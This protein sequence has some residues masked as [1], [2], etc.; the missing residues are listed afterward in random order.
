MANTIKTKKPSRKSSQSSVITSSQRILKVNASLKVENIQLRTNVRTLQ[1][2][3]S[4]IKKTLSQQS[5]KEIIRADEEKY[6][7]I[8]HSSMDIIFM[9]D[10]AGK[11]L[12]VNDSMGNKLGYTTEELIGKSFAIFVPQM[13]KAKYRLELKNIYLRKEVKH[14][15]TKIYRKD[16]TLVDVEINGKLIKHNRANVGLGTIRDITERKKSEQKIVEVQTM[17]HRIINLLPVRVFWKDKNLK[18]LGCNEIFAKDAGKKHPNELLGKDDTTLVWKEQATL[19]QNDDTVIIN[20]GKPK[21]HFEEPQTTSNGKKVWLSTSKVPLT[22][23]EG[24]IIGVLGA[25]E[26]IT[27]RKRAEL[28]L[29]DSESKYHELY[30]LIRLMSDTMPDL[31]WAKDLDNKYIF[32]NKAMCDK[33][34]GAVDTSEP[35]G[36]TDLFFALRERQAHPEDPQWHTFGELCRDS[37]EVVVKEMKEMQ[38]D[39]YGNVKGKFLFLDVHKAPLFNDE[40]KLIGVVGS[41]RDIT[42]RK[43]IETELKKSQDRLKMFFNQSLD[44]FYFSM[45]DEPKAWNEN[46]NKEEILDYVFSH[47][48]MTEINDAMLKQYG[49]TREYFLHKSL[50]SFFRHDEEQGRLLRRKLFDDGHLHVE[51]N[52][53]KVDGTP[54]WIEGDYVCL[55]DD[56]H[57]ILGTFGIQRDITER[58]RIEEAQKLS[59]KRLNNVL[60]NSPDTIYTIDL[61]TGKANLLN[62]NDFYGYTKQELESSKS[63]LHTIFPDDCNIVFENWEKMR[64]GK[65]IEPIEYRIVKKDGEIVWI[66]QRITV[67]SRNADNTPNQLLVT[68]SDITVRKRTEETLRTS[69]EHQRFILQS[70][71]VAIYSS[72]MDPN[73]DTNWISGDVKRVTG[74]EVEEYLSEPDFW[75]KRIHPDDAESIFEMYKTLSFNDEIILEYR[76]KCKDGAYHWF[77]DRTILKEKENQKEYLGIIT[78]VTERKKSENLI[79][80]SEISYRGLFN[81]VSDAIY[82]LNEKGQFIDVNPGALK[83]YGYQYE[84]LVG[85]TPEFVS[86]PG[87]NDMAMVVEALKKAMEGEPQQ[88][89]FWGLR[90]NGEI[91]LKDVRLNKGTYFGDDVIIALAQDISE[92]KKS[93]KKI[94]ENEERYRIIVDNLHQAYFEADGRAIFTYFN[95]ELCIISGFNDHELI[96]TSSLRLV[97]KEHR[98]RVTESYFRW[99]K[100]KCTKSSIEFLTQKKN[101]EKI[102]VEQTTHFEFDENG[103][104]IKGANII[105]DIHERKMAEEALITEKNLLMTLVNTIPDRVYVKDKESRFLL[106]NTAHLHALGAQ[107]QSEAL[108]KTDHDFRKQEFADQYLSDDRSVIQTDTPINNKEELTI[109]PSGELGT[110][111]VNKV[112]LHN[113]KG[114]VIGLVGVSRDISERKRLEEGIQQSEIFFRSV[115]EHSSSGMRLTDENGI[116]I[117]VNKSFCNM[118]GKTEK[119]LVGSS[120]SVIYMPEAHTHIVQKHMERFSTRSVPISTEQELLLWNGK[121]VWFKVL[122]SFIEFGSTKSLLLGIFSDITEQ[123]KSEQIIQDLQRRESIGILAGGIAHDFNNLLASMMGNL[124]L[125][126]TRMVSDHPAIKNLDRTMVAVERAATLTK[127]MLAYSGKGRFQSIAIDL[128][129]VVKEHIELFEAS[130][131]KNVSIVTHL[132][133]NPVFIKGDPGQIEQ[134]IMNLIINGGEAIGEKNG[135]VDISVFTIYLTDEE[136]EPFGKYNNKEMISGEYALFQVVDNGIGIR[137]ETIAKIFDPF[138]TTK[139]VGRGL[140]LSAVLGI[141]RG[142]G[143]GIRVSSKENVGTTFQVIIPLLKADIE[144]YKI[145]H[146]DYDERSLSPTVLVIDDEQYIIDMTNDI[147]ESKKYHHYS[148]VDP[149]KGIS[150]FKDYWQSIDLVILDYAMPKMNGKEVLIELLKINPAIKVIMSSGYSEEELIHLMG[151]IKPSAFIQKPHRPEKLLSLITTVLNQS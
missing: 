21:L 33:L 10:K 8:A 83:M 124:S 126:K 84:E 4:K 28:A 114:D 99:K 61:A 42:E 44:G 41:G 71:P 140:G 106:N 133:P 11:I 53:L 50:N 105:K 18:Y 93:E 144:E 127:Q 139:F 60:E 137:E 143:G 66:G 130:L 27:E 134:I 92:R 15:E 128:V 68:L 1:Q 40:G 76:W 117:T 75:R 146:S 100:E 80:E 39:E 89:E 90:K 51:T 151:D 35:V 26:D 129:K 122:N 72:P 19:Y 55:Y 32:A 108:G 91:F 147:F 2:E 22:D 67:M 74:F 47:Q 57:R 78:D 6:K 95:Q 14:F 131:P 115:W 16:G 113:S 149:V 62:R 7:M 110:V 120:L 86:A 141:I 12:F 29:K 58:K 20:S 73:I 132:S 112:P 118:V 70:M 79:L 123:K 46:S 85:K 119:E 49:A 98:A 101:G 148:A 77:Q 97:A 135:N 96:G 107:T 52:E 94:R 69:E 82:F 36:K 150:L 111:L 109:L 13:E 56:Q 102:W 25:Y 81:N 65:E 24:N 64:A 145:Q 63:I 88:F 38:F 104:F 9:I 17:L 48:R 87:K 45:L 142:H 138:F 30:S 116:I 23:I 125:A 103:R 59:E 121:K 54:I 34:L 5:A 37:D 136:L 43:R 3:I 31:V